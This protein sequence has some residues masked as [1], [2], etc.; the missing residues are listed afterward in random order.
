MTELGLVAGNI[1][2][3][4]GRFVLTTI[5][6]FLAFLLF[7]TVAGFALSLSGAADTPEA[8]RLVVT[9]RV[10]LGQSL[11]IA[12]VEEI[13]RETG[14]AAV[15]PAIVFAGYGGDR[16]RPVIAFAVDPAGWMAVYPEI[17]IAPA[18]LA[19]FRRDPDGVLVGRDLAEQFGWSVGDEIRLGS[20]LWRNRSG[21]TAWPMS[22]HGVF[23]DDS[24]TA[25]SGYLLMQY[26]Y[27][28]ASRIGQQNTATWA[29]V[30]PEPGVSPTALA[31]R[32]D[33]R[34]SN[35]A[36]ETKTQSEAS[37]GAEFLRQFGD[38]ALAL[39][40]VLS[41]SFV[42]LLFIVGST[43]SMSVRD[44]RSE[45]AVLRALGFP[46]HRI[47]RS[48]LLEGV[49]LCAFGGFCG[50]ALSALVLTALGGVMETSL[51]TLGASPAVL[52]LGV[53]LIV[54]LGAL[55]ALPPAMSADRIPVSAAFSRP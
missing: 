31:D 15:S 50:L 14:V 6:V 42:S 52:L 25:G 27:L 22:V 19:A 5:A 46:R 23:D 3:R 53:G 18:A 12:H 44:R 32:I 34:F 1:V 51:P 48:I 54:S 47:L 26:E 28:N 8:S 41:A 11:P 40:L 10:G 55:S 21:E 17:S 16:S 33:R 35:S 7:G 43:I 36:F 37:F 13:R 38:V 49:G 39:G 2:R 30:T 45:I 9:S 20:L 29:V 4:P 24:T